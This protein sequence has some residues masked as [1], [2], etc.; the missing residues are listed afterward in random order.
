M[1]YF[2]QQTMVV[3]IDTDDVTT[4]QDKVT[5]RRLT[6]E[7]R[8]RCISLSMKVTSETQLSRGKKGATKG[9]RAAGEDQAAEVVIDGA[10][11]AAEQVAA[12]LVS[13]EGPGFE[14][15]PATRD[16]LF[17]LPPEIVDKIS[18]A[19]DVLNQGLSDEEK[20]R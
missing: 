7:E 4:A 11:M 9:A 1:G 15:R 8:Q 6:Y 3:P 10:L 19:A 5:I 16:N 20:N 13:W 2:T 17:A 18:A 14:G 12:A